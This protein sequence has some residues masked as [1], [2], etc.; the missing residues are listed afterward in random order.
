MI[1]QSAVKISSTLFSVLS[2][3]AFIVDAAAG[4]HDNY[5]LLTLPII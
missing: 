4:V 1:P 3:T 5:Y 2:H